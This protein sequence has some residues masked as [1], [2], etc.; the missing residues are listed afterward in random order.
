M[1]VNKSGFIIMFLLV[2]FLASIPNLAL[3]SPLG[4]RLGLQGTNLH[5]EWDQV[6]PTVDGGPFLTWGIFIFSER[7]GNIFVCGSTITFVNC[8]FGRETTSLDIDLI[9]RFPGGLP[10]TIPVSASIT[11]FYGPYPG[12]SWITQYI[13]GAGGTFTFPPL[14]EKVSGDTPIQEGPINSTLPLLMVVKTTDGKNNPITE[15]KV[16]WTIIGPP[17]ASGQRVFLTPSTTGLGGQAQV[18]VILGDKPG[19]YTITATCL[20][21]ISGSPQ[22]FTAIATVNKILSK[23]SG[24]TPIQEGPV[25]SLLPLPMVVKVTDA[26]GNPVSGGQI[27]WTITGPPGATGKSVSPTTGTQVNVRL[28]NKSGNY[29]ITAT[30]SNC[31]SGS[32]KTFTATAKATDKIL[33]IVSGGGQSGPVGTALPQPLVVKV[34]DTQDNPVGGVTVTFEITQQ[35][36]GAKAASP[37]STTKTTGESDGKA[38]ASLTLGDL[39]DSYTVKATCSDCTPNSVTFNA[40]AT[41]EACTQNGAKIGSQVGFLSGNLFYTQNILTLSGTGPQA[42]LTLAYNSIDNTNSSLSSHWTHNYAMKIERDFDGFITL[43]EEDGKRIVFIEQDAD[44]FVPIDHFGRSGTTIER[45]SDARYQLRRKDGTVYIFD[46]SGRLTQIQDRNLN[47]LSLVYNGEN[48]TQLIDASGRI[49]S[50]GYDGQGRLVSIT[51]PAGRVTTMGYS[52]GGF[53]SRATDPSE[54]A[55]LFTYDG[56]GLMI[57]RI[58]PDGSE[59]SYGYDSEGRLISATD[60]SGIPNTV[61]YQPESSQATLTGR[62]GGV[63]TYLYDPILDKPLLIIAPDG[64]MTSN[65]YDTKGNL[66]STIDPSGN[67][68]SYAYDAGGNLFTITDPQGGITRY[69]YD[70]IF[71]LVTSITDPNGNI[72]AYTYDGLGNLLSLNDPTGGVTRYSYD[73]QGRLI[74]LTNPSGQTTSFTYDASGNLISITDPTGAT[75]TM[76]YDQAGNMISRTDPNGAT[77]Y[78]EYDL[79]NRLIKTIDPLGNATTFIYDSRGNRIS[80]TDAMGRTTQYEY[81]YQNKLIKVIDP[82][83]GITSYAYDAKGNLTSITDAIG[84][85]TAY[86]YDTQNRLISETDP[87]G[88]TIRYAYDT[89]GNLIQKT[90]GNGQVIS[91]TYDSLNRLTRKNYTDGG[92]DAFTYDSN[93]RIISAGNQYIS[94]ALGYDAAGRITQ[95]T[96]SRGYTVRYRYDVAGNRTNLTYPDGGSATYSY[97]TA[98]RLSAMTDWTGRS[99]TFGYDRLGRRTGL[100]YSNGTKASYNYDQASR[101]TDLSHKAGSGSILDSFSYTYDPMGNRLSVNMPKE[102][103]NYTY[104]LLDRLIQT[105]PTKLLGTDIEMVHKAEAFNYDPVGNR[106]TG[107]EAIDTYA[108]NQG[109]QLISDRKNQYQYDRNGNLISKTEVGDDGT[110]KNWT[111]SYDAENRLIK[112]IKQE[113]SGTKTIT[114]KYDPFGRRIEKKV[115]GIEAGIA[116]T[117]TYSYVYDN[118]AIILEYLTKTENGI[119]RTETTKY[120]HGLGIDE[121]LAI[122]RKGEAFYYHADGLGSVAALTD[123][124]QKAMESYSYSSFGDIKRQGDKVKNTYTFTGREFD[125]EIDLYYY[126]ARYYDAETGRF[127]SFDPIL[128]VANVLPTDEQTQIIPFSS[129]ELILGKTGLLNPYIYVINNPLSA[130]DPSGLELL[131]LQE[132]I[133]IVQQANGWIGAPYKIGGNS[134]NGID[135]SHLVQSVYSGAGSSYLYVTTSG[136]PP[137]DKFKKVN[138]PQEGDVVL[139]SGHMGIYTG[140]KIISAQSGAGKVVL[141]EMSWFG[142]VK[143]YYRYDKKCGQ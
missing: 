140:G 57:S 121:P 123:S 74:R 38:S 77:T 83:G 6:P 135:C 132:G 28:G 33:S 50:L 71:N 98:N 43:K 67:T 32:P 94:Y 133:A 87:L 100:N 99:T 54:K 90:D 44:L 92:F 27:N 142:A 107:P 56:T 2:I 76:T 127:I 7:Y 49:T 69:S 29:T 40:T 141:G 126:R 89:K 112:V 47:T 24:D 68:T 39:P 113:A 130:I 131:S 34:A 70:P 51:D 53:L 14:L 16:D 104:D 36:E 114:F 124:R 85:T 19:S 20:N 48:L 128:R 3:A 11:A 111:Y 65:T 139:F 78:F 41:A 18:A 81:N 109:N 119:S 86:S 129:P 8:S 73:A 66:I 25:N 1:Y 13:G 96:D 95:S 60:A 75:T 46:P 91:F 82:Q 79:L 45:L 138:S 110:T 31:T 42:N 61:S 143:G 105:T 118:E 59:V 88:N 102:K 9:Q 23:V 10:Q 103:I 35:P 108:Y 21:C 116:G 5:V 93:G 125:E 80:Q 122:E 64:G 58:D 55:T 117:K 72:T 52:A 37:Q 26:S 63:T 120:L 101:L 84:Q 106:I 97:D 22:T 62:D 17:G 30:C 15:V 12:A 137:P 4:V 136:F 134:R 115:E